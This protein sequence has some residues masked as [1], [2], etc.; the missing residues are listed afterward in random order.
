MVDTIPHHQNA[1]ERSGRTLT[2]LRDSK[3][4]QPFR[5]PP[6]NT[7]ATWKWSDIR[8]T[9]RVRLKLDLWANESRHVLE[10]NSG[11]LMPK[12]TVAALDAFIAA[13]NEIDAMM[14]RLVAHSADDFG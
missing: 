5:F 8:G 14:G 10:T 1:A 12:T 3:G 4:L 7:H 9:F 11:T 2:F 6:C 13:K